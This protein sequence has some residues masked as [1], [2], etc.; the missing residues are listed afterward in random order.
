MVR[1]HVYRSQRLDPLDHV[2][3]T[4]RDSRASDPQCLRNAPFWKAT[5]VLL[6]SVWI[7]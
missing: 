7:L 2:S 1:P 6:R 4:L 5:R 3:Q